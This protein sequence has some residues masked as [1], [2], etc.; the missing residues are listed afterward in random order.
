MLRPHHIV[1]GEFRKTHA[2]PVARLTGSS[3]ADRVGQD[4][5]MRGAV[6]QLSGP[7]K[8]SGEC[9][10]QKTVAG[11]PGTVQDQD[12]VHYF[13]AGIS[14]GLADGGVMLPPFRKRLAARKLEVLDDPIALYG[15]RALGRHGEQA[16]G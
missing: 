3:M 8:L 2:Q 9:F 12:S 1:I 13:A 5:V 4:N 7:E 15:R 16:G 11:S 10:F 14:L 6:E